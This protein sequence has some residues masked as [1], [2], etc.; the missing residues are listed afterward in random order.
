MRRV[1][2][3][4]P[5]SPSSSQSRIQ[6]SRM[7]PAT[8]SAIPSWASTVHHPSTTQQSMVLERDEALLNQK[9]N[10]FVVKIADEV[11]QRE[12]QLRMKSVLDARRAARQQK[13]KTL[14]P[15][16][17]SASGTHRT[18]RPT[19]SASQ[20]PPRGPELAF[21]AKLRTPAQSI[22][23]TA[24]LVRDDI[25]AWSRTI[26]CE[27]C[28]LQHLREVVTTAL[29]PLPRGSEVV[30]VLALNPQGDG[31]FSA[32]PSFASLAS[33]S[34]VKPVIVAQRKSATRG[35][36]FGSLSLGSIPIRK[37]TFVAT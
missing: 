16:T 32:I 1:L 2:Q 11:H 15:L 35:V 13:K 36:F 18:S 37:T 10:D 19:S 6:S 26:D 5:Q 27:V 3:S 24:T 30:S 29:G 14:A 33:V 4:R 21:K 22:H 7:R 28:S 8:P 9:I 25:P 23:V 20:P 31:T 34:I 17:H 12:H